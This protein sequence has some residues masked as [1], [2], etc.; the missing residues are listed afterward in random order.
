[1]FIKT[2]QHFHTKRYPYMTDKSESTVIN[3]NKNKFE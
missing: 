3:N 1:M 2:W